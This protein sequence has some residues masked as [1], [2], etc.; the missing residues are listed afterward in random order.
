MAFGDAHRR[1]VVGRL[2]L[3]EADESPAGPV[4][5]IEPVI[6]HMSPQLSLRNDSESQMKC[7]MNAAETT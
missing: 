2:D 5:Q 7:R 1:D 4:Q 6:A 3:L